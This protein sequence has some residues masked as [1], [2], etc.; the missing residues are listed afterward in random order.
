MKLRVKLTI[1]AVILGMLMIPAYF[2]LQTFGVFQKR[3]SI[4]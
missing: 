2:I 4:I 1:F 3:D